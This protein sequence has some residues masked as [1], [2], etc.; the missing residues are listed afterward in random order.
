M[1]QGEKGHKAMQVHGPATWSVNFIWCWKQRKTMKLKKQQQHRLQTTQS[2]S[3]NQ[4][5]EKMSYART[6]QECISIPLPLEVPLTGTANPLVQPC[7]L[8]PIT[9][10]LYTQ[11]RKSHPSESSCGH[12]NRFLESIGMARMSYVN[13]SKRE[14]E[15]SQ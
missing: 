3:E 9:L 8:E 5:A 14:A 2:R 1:P 11:W 6:K 15:S 13:S 4:T 12:W 7:P 10:E